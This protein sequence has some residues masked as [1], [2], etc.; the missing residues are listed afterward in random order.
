MEARTQVSLDPEV[1][2]RAK[3]RAAALGVSLAEYVR[4]LVA[5]DLAH[6]RPAADPSVVFNLG[7]SGGSDIARSKDRYVGEAVGA[8]RSGQAGHPRSRR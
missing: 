6:P 4:G 2:R 3:E 8:G 7:D 5:R 1:L